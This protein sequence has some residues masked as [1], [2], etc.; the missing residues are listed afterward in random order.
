MGHLSPRTEQQNWSGCWL[1]WGPGL[2][3]PGRDSQAQPQ[4]SLHWGAGVSNGN[5]G[6]RGASEPE[7]LARRPQSCP[8]T[9]WW[10]AL[11]SLLLPSSWRT[12]LFTGQTPRGARC[13]GLG[14]TWGAGHP[15]RLTLGPKESRLPLGDATCQG[16]EAESLGPASLPS[17]QPVSPFGALSGLGQ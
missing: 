10:P 3:W 11:D 1:L 8:A 14:G 13:Q 2:C 17:C 7:L 9:D 12:S 15:A 4:R 6:G 16:G 5:G